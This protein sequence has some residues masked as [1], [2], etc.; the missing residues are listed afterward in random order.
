MKQTKE[1]IDDSSWVNEWIVLF[2]VCVVAFI[3]VSL[4]AFP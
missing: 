3:I 2:V 4:V 1:Q